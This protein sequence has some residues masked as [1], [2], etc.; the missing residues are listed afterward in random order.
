MN[1]RKL[2]QFILPLAIVFTAGDIGQ[3]VLNGGMARVPDVIATLA[4]YGL[5]LGIK[6]LLA[7]PIT[8][9][10]QLGLVL[11]EDHRARRLNQPCQTLVGLLYC[12]RCNL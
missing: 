7:T 10:G 4:A 5:A 11:T 8:Q 12:L 1:Y 9:V 3:Q 6:A 2:I